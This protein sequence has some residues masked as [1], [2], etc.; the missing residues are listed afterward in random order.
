MAF[1][2]SGHRGTH[3]ADLLSPCC[4]AKAKGNTGSRQPRPTLPSIR[5]V[6]QHTLWNGEWR[7]VS[8]G[9]TLSF[10]DGM[11]QAGYGRPLFHDQFAPTDVIVD[12]WRVFK[13]TMPRHLQ[14]RRYVKLREED[15]RR[16]IEKAQVRA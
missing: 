5:A 2:W 9:L 7:T 12:G 13:N 10:V 4:H 15:W 6:T 8:N 16:L 11:L 1:S 3:L 14:E